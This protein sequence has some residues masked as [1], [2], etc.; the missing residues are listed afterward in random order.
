[1]VKE[2]TLRLLQDN[3]IP[4]DQAIYYAGSMIVTKRNNCPHDG[5]LQEDWH[6]EN[7]LYIACSL[8]S[9]VIYYK[10]SGKF[11]L[12]LNHLN[13]IKVTVDDDERLAAF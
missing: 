2:E 4:A 9:K 5:S 11:Y 3:K 12:I 7:N 10:N 8:C 13:P 6:S 1:M